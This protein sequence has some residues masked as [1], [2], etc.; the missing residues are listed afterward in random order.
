[1]KNFYVH[2]DVMLLTLKDDLI[3]N[4]T[5]PGKFQGYLASKKPIVGMV[6]G[7]SY[8]LIKHNKCGFAVNSGNY[9]SL[10]K[11]IIRIFEK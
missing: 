7:E 8:D 2:A 11:I 9:R 1:M 4:Y 5:V 6:N 10:S 3:Y